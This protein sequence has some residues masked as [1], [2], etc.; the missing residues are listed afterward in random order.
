MIRPVL[1]P[2]VVISEAVAAEAAVSASLDPTRLPER[3]SLEQ[4][5]KRAKRMLRDA[6]RGQAS[7]LAALRL[8]P[9]LRALG[10]AEL[11]N[12]ARLADAQLVVARGYGFASW[13]VW[14]RFVDVQNLER[15]GR[16]SRLLECV[17][18][19]D[20]GLAL[21]LLGADP[22]LGRHD[23]YTA[24]ACGELET[25]RRLLERDP[26]LVHAR[27][28][29]LDCPALVYACFSRF[30]RRD[31]QRAGRIH[32]LVAE[33]LGRGA[34]PDA[35]F[36]RQDG[37]D[38]VGQ[39]CLY[40]AAGI[41][42]DATLTRLLLEA[43]A[44]IDERVPEP[45]R[46]ALY[47]ASEFSDVTCLGLLLEARPDPAFVTYCLSR[48]L[49]FDND[50]AVELYLEH[51]ADPNHRVP[52]HNAQGHLHKAVIQRRSLRTV[53]ALLERG[54]DPNL[55]D[56][57]GLSPYR[58]AVRLGQVEMVE[59]FAAHGAN[60]D[61]ATAEERAM[62]ALASGASSQRVTALVLTD[63]ERL[64]RAAERNDVVLMQRLLDAGADVNADVALPPLHAACVA[65]RFDA[66]AL[67]IARGANLE[68]RNVYGGDVI[69]ATVWGSDNH[70]PTGGQPGPD[71][72]APAPEGEWSRIIELLIESGARRPAHVV[73]GNEAIQDT[74]RR[75]GV[76]DAP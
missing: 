64:S 47:H 43:G 74:L 25:A 3:P 30:L 75:L 23:L 69:G 40:G 37:S 8:H 7:A 5:R 4:D 16:A 62:G 13:P 63:R 61:E 51:G 65:G 9:R 19:N 72:L 17:C 33:L 38:R 60:L 10:D 2:V 55:P 50:R 48:A 45:A 1:S 6:R 35:H 36:V 11:Q 18:G 71:W 42:N 15:A 52:W 46:E 34:N 12:V 70:P 32:T 57:H 14:K 44:D 27:G 67:L 20:L 29:P 73:G 68:Q 53:R 49:D 31:P 76:P 26:A 54:A 58:Y 59:L 56:A 24:C 21:R 66:V 28:G 39:T 41:A 22:E